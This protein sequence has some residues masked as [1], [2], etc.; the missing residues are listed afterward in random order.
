[1]RRAREPRRGRCTR[2]AQNCNLSSSPSELARKGYAAMKNRAVIGSIEAAGA[3][4][5]GARAAAP[6]ATETTTLTQDAYRRL[7]EMIVTSELAPGE[8]VSEAILSRRIGIGTTPIREALHRLAREH[9]VQIMPRRAVVVTPVDVGLQ[10]Q[11]LETRR[12]LDRLLARAA[13]QRATAAERQVIAE[14]AAAI[15]EAVAA[16]DLREF[17]RLDAERARWLANGARN[18]I[19][20]G[21]AATL[22]SV[23]R[24]FW[25]YY[26]REDRHFAET[27][28]LHVA[29]MMAIAAGDAD[30]A[31]AA[32]DQLIEYMIAFAKATLPG[33]SSSTP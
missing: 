12:E 7:E 29:V 5:R 11:V 3:A 18:T 26:L 19:A 1:M 24:R 30:G 23:S 20:A 10:F 8:A 6:E 17:L 13:A 27:A 4:A 15:E 16:D 31:G 25:F 14:L 2:Q 28:R 9:L 33:A 22:H 32:S 21:I